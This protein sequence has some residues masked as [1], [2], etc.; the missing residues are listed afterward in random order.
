MQ[1]FHSLLSCEQLGYILRA[2]FL[3]SLCIIM[4]LSIILHL[5]HNTEGRSCDIESFVQEWLGT[6]MVI[7]L[8]MLYSGM[9]LWYLS[10]SSP[11]GYYTKWDCHV[12]Y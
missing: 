6:T 10:L 8:M 1:N 12:S 2:L 11:S 9:E 7:K 4:L 3:I 5:Y